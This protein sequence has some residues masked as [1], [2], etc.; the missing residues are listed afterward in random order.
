[1]HVLHAVGSLGL[2]SSVGICAGVV[3]EVTQAVEVFLFKTLKI[4]AIERAQ[5]LRTLTE[6]RRLM[7]PV[8][9]AS[10][11]LMGSVH[12]PTLTSHVLKMK[13]LLKK[14]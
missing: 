3:Q 12:T 10:A 11:D 8:T 2:C 7:T 4:G 5:Q 9:P 1:M 6:T 14:I 13:S